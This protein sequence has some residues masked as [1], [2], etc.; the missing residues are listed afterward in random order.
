MAAGGEH[1]LDVAAE[2]LGAHPAQ[3]GVL[4]EGR[5]ATALAD[6][7][8]QRVGGQERVGAGIEGA[9]PEVADQ[10]VE[11]DGITRAAFQQCSGFDSTIDVIEQELES[12]VRRGNLTA[13]RITSIADPQTYSSYTATQRSALTDSEVLYYLGDLSLHMG[14]DAAAEQR[15]EH[16]ADVA[17]GE[18]IRPGIGGAIVAEA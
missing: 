6:L 9:F 8:R 4:D 14:S 13:Q 17:G 2:H 10:L 15:I 16:R 18:D 5:V 7:H 12:Y 1:K 11:I 3:P